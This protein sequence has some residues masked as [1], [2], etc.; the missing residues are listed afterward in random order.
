MYYSLTTLTTVGYG[1]YYPISI[2]EQLLGSVIQLLGVTFFSVL[3]NKF[4]E[5]VLQFKSDSGYNDE[6]KL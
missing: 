2:P 6:L 1:D 3:M 5:V 4:I